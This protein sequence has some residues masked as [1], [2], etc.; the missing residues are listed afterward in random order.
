M[1]GLV[2]RDGR[3]TEGV[4]DEWETRA[5]CL[6]IVER[7]SILVGLRAGESFNVIAGQLDRRPST[8]SLRWLRT[9]AM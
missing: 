4:P 1:V 6:T 5:G 3:F 2:G 9:A 7:K 8:V